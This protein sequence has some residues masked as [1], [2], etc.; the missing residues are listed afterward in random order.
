MPRIPLAADPDLQ[1]RL[2]RS[3]GGDFRAE[4]GPEITEWNT[5]DLVAEL[6][7]LTREAARLHKFKSRVEFFGGGCGVAFAFFGISDL[8]VNHVATGLSLLLC[9]GGAL[10]FVLLT[11]RSSE[12]VGR[13]IS[14][15]IGA[16][17]RRMLGH[18]RG[19]GTGA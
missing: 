17:Q 13:R 8:A 10:L 2:R 15:R 1:E 7:H 11:R 3:G 16:I 4:A 5:G 12:A 9:G 14:L 18:R 19:L 6:E